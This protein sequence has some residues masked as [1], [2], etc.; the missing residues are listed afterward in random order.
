MLPIQLLI[1][2]GS[3]F[4]HDSAWQPVHITISLL[5]CLYFAGAKRYR[6]MAFALFLLFW[7]VAINCISTSTEQYKKGEILPF[8]LSDVSFAQIKSQSR[9]YFSAYMSVP[10][11]YNLPMLQNK[12]LLHLEAAFIKRLENKEI[13]LSSN[14]LWQ[15]EGRSRITNLVYAN[16]HGNWRERWLYQKGFVAEL[17]LSQP[18]EPVRV[19]QQS[20]GFEVIQS[21]L[22]TTLDD[23]FS[24]FD[25]WRFSRSLFLGES[26][27]L[28][29][30]DK[31]LIRFSGLSHL[32]VVS[33]LH[34]GFVYLLIV[35]VTKLIWRLSPIYLVN[36]V[37]EES[38]LVLI[39]SVPCL[40][41]YGALTGW[42]EPV[43]RAVFMLL[44]WQIVNL[45]GIKTTSNNILFL[46]L[47]IISLLF[48]F[49]V[50]SASLWLSFCLVF[51]III[52]GKH[53]GKSIINWVTMQLMLTF[54]AVGLTLGWQ[55]DISAMNVLFNLIMVPFTALFWFPATFFSC[56][57]LLLF[58]ST[59][60]M[61]LVDTV[62]YYVW[63][64]LD[65]LV[66]NS[67]A[68]TLNLAATLPVKI[69]V[70]FLIFIWVLYE[71]VTKFS[72]GL[73][74][75]ASFFVLN[76][77]SFNSL[78]ETSDEKPVEWTINNQNNGIRLYSIAKSGTKLLLNTHWA[79]HETELGDYWLNSK[80]VNTLTTK[81]KMAIYIW[82]LRQSQIT[83]DLLKRLS[84]QWLILKQEPTETL[85][86]L[87]TALQ[88]D[89][90]VV[91]K[92]QSIKIEF[93]Q[94]YWYIR[95]S[96]CLITVKLL[97]EKHCQRI[98]Q[99]ENMIN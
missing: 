69:M 95:H 55:P 67:K 71:K 51:L 31:W 74:V 86:A 25:S 38:V 14:T 72:Y 92:K 53:R 39:F 26:G 2:I 20:I 19:S 29:N 85:Q 41:F 99:L 50:Y 27:R 57:E 30:K 66:F 62:M 89:W 58:D 59:W 1:L 5:C 82:P 22:L 45:W 7:S 6:S 94:E 91:T 84:P 76:I 52:Y 33:G 13:L 37:K 17:W 77:S 47:L 79:S 46:T 43:T 48:P 49:S 61:L 40:F 87:L 98:V 16:R 34:V 63:L 8:S 75:A 64:T 15:V 70:L 65:F 83:A 93:W 88:I 42:G 23:G 68:I 9:E 90:L 36:I 4:T 32:F 96:N 56:L 80:I 81:M 18:L 28:S 73:L 54:S 60:L 78:M 12:L 3:L 10:T 97:Q 21:R 24:T 35:F 11:K 44:I